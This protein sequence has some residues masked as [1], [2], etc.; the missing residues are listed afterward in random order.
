MACCLPKC[1][2]LRNH[3][4]VQTLLF[5]LT[6]ESHPFTNTLASAITSLYS[7]FKSHAFLLSNPFYNQ[8][9]F[10]ADC[11]NCSIFIKHSLTS[12]FLSR[13]SLHKRSQSSTRSSHGNLS[14]GSVTSADNHSADEVEGTVQPCKAKVAERQSNSSI[15]MQGKRCCILFVKKI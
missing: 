1:S 5:S 10:C 9:R 8:Q 6:S 11:F 4:P 12:V 7:A 14:Q 13:M 2:G 15:D 3:C